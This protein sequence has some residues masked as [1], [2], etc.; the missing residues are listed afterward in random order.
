M[1]RPS[2]LTRVLAHKVGCGASWFITAS[3]ICTFTSTAVAQQYS[4]LWGQN[5]E[6]WNPA[7]SLLRD[8]TNVGYMG[9]TVPIPNWPVGVN[10]TD[11]GAIPNDGIDD[12]QAIINAIAACPH[13]HAVLV[14]KG[15][16]T[17]LQ[18]IIPARDNFV[19]R[20]EH[21][22]ESVLFF[23]KYVGEA[24]I[25]QVGWTAGRTSVDRNFVEDAFLQMNGGTG[26][27]IEN[28]SFE[29][30]EQRKASPWDYPGANAISYNNGIT[31]SWVRNVYMKNY[32]L[33]IGVSGTQLSFI[34]I[35]AD[36]FYG[37]QATDGDMSGKLDAFSAILPRN[38]SHNLYHNIDITGVVLQPIDLNGSV[39][40]SVFSKIRTSEMNSR[41]VAYHGGGSQCNLYTDLNRPVVGPFI[42][43]IYEPGSSS[44]R[45]NETYWGAEN[46]RLSDDTWST[47]TNR[48]IFVGYGN[49]WATR[50][51]TSLW[52]A[53]TPSGFWYEPDVPNLVIP[54]NLYLAQLAR[55]GEP[56]P[57]NLP[58]PV[59][60]PYEIAG[61]VFRMLPTDDIT[62]GKNSTDE[63]TAA[64]SYLKFDLTGA[65]E[66]AVAHARL[67]LT[68]K[69]IQNTPFRISAWTVTND[70][71]SETTLT[72]ANKPAVV[73]ELETKWIL[74][75]NAD[76][77]VEFDVTAFARNELVGGDRVISLCVKKQ[78]GNGFLSS[79]WSSEL[80]V[81]PELVIERT[82][83]S[84]PSPPSAPKGIRS[85]PL[86]GNIILDWDDNN[87]T[88]VETY[89]VY[90]T[91]YDYG[92][93]PVAAGLV[94]SDYVD[95]SSESDWHVGMMDYR[96]V[97]RY[98]I[99][100]VDDHG[101]ESPRSDVFVAATLHPTNA[102][103]AF[104]ATVNLAGGTAAA[105]YVGSLAGTASDP[106]SDPLFFMKV[107]GPDWLKV[108]LDGTLS[109]TP[110]L[111][112][113]GLHT[114]TF[115]VTAIGGNALKEVT[116]LVGPPVD[117]P[118]GAPAP[119]TSLNAVPGDA[120]VALN[121]DDNAEANLA[122][123]K[124]YRAS[125]SSGPYSVI[126]ASVATSSY[127]DQ[128][129]INGT[130]YHYYVTAVNTGAIE[131]AASNGVSASPLAPPPPGP[132][133]A[134]NFL[135]GLLTTPANWSNGLPLGQLGGIAVNSTVDTAVVLGGY[136]ILHTAGTVQQAGLNALEMING[137][138]WVTDGV[139]ATTATNFR[140]FALK[141]GSS[142]TLNQGTI[143]TVSGRD[144]SVMDAGSSLTVNGGS[145]ILGRSLFLSGTAGPAFTINGG[146]ISLNGTSG[147]IGA[148]SIHGNAK[149]F[150]FNG[151]ST[152]VYRL[153][154]AGANT[155]FYFGGS[156][157]GSLTATSFVGSIGTNSFLNFLPGTK[158]ALTLFGMDEWAA[159]Q[160]AAGKLR[161]NGQGVSQLGSWTAVTAANGLEPGAHFVYDSAAETLT[162]VTVD[163][164]PAAPLNLAATA[165]DST[166]NLAWGINTE[167]DFASYTIY[168]SETSGSG[169]VAIATG[170]TANAYMDLNVFNGTTYRYV[171]T[172]TDA[173]ANESGVST[174]VSAT[175]V[176]M[177]P[178]ASPTG[179]AVWVGDGMTLLNWADNSESD[180]GGYAVY[181]STTL[182]SGYSAI[183]SSLASSTY[184]DE[185]VTNGTTYHYVITALDTVGNE[186]PWGNPVSATPQVGL[187]ITSNFLGG[188]LTD[189]AN[190]NL[191]LP[192]IFL[193]SVATN[194]TVDTSIVLNGY[195]I[196]HSAGTIQ[197]TGLNALEMIN[198]S[199]WVTDGPTATTATGFRGFTL[200]S[201]SSF[202]LNQGTIHTVSG[203]DWSVMDAGS[204]LTVNGG[205]L[206]LGRHLTL[207]GTAGPTFT[208]NGGVIN[209][210][211]TTGDI[212]ASS[213]HSNAKAF[214]F[215]GGTTT[216]FR[217]NL[218]GAN[219]VFHFGGT[220]AGS[221][222]ATNFAG[223]IGTNSFLN[224]L[225]GTQMAV[226]LT[227]ANEWAATQWAAGKL[228]YNGQGNSQLGSWAAVTATGGLG[229]GYRFAYDSATETLSLTTA[230]SDDP[231]A[232][233]TGLSASPGI[234]SVSLDWANNS[235]GDLAGYSVYRS[236]S[237][238][239]LGLILASGLPT[240]QYVDSSVVDNT[241]YH[242]TVTAVDLAAQASEPSSQTS[243]RPGFVTHHTS[244]EI[245][246]DGT[247]AGSIGNVDTRDNSYQSIT[248][249][250]N[251]TTSLLEH[252]WVF[253]IT[254]AEIVTFVVEAY[255]S[256]NSESDRF[257]FAYSTDEVN[258]TD[259][260][261]ADK[262]AA[263]GTAQ[264]HVL[265]SGTSGTVY[266]R[267]RD[268]D[269]S[270]GNNGLDSINI[271]QLVIESE[272][273]STPPAAASAPSP[274]NSA[275]EVSD[276]PV[277]RWKAGRGTVSHEVY[278]GTTT[279]P[280]LLGIQ[281]GT[282]STPGLLLPNT[283]YYWS[284][285]EVNSSGTTAGPIWSFTTGN[286]TPKL[287]T[288]LIA[289]VGSVWQ[290]IELPHTY[291]SPVVVASVVYSAKTVAPAVARVRN[292]AGNSL[293]LKVQNPSGLPLSDYDVYLVVIEEGVYTAAEHGVNLEALKVD[294]VGRNE[295]NNWT[296]SQQ[297]PISPT[298]SFITPVVLGQ[299]MT[300]DDGKWSVFWSSSANR[301]NPASASSIHVGRHVGEDTDLI[302]TPETLGVIIV[303]A[304]SATF[305]GVN[306]TAQVGTDSVSG[307]G[308]NPP[309]SYP[310]T[311]LF[312][313]SG[314]AISSAAMDGN[315]GSWPVLLG[316]A[317]VT[318]TQLFLAIDE[319][320][321]ADAERKH[322][323]EQ[324]SYLVFE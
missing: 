93:L 226:T 72:T 227:A 243:A 183:A 177:T 159:T 147:D 263:D 123:Y 216:T 47:S 297:V 242:Y 145:L 161:Y 60:A 151:G 236:T 264:Y 6:L 186:S 178:P 158:M 52:N 23:P 129:A 119:P 250:S 199:T 319:D 135:G 277:L 19:L 50:I 272:T 71:W 312:S 36:Q 222:T 133:A 104:N 32:D 142:F 33:G 139:T 309:Y 34:N 16:F 289:D 258:Y 136:N 127:T 224:F 208:I 150:N 223:A 311:G 181:R 75:N 105:N 251:G 173:G 300:A 213:I 204:S 256:P 262:T 185:T 321:I 124:V 56:L 116:I 320:Q 41:T 281:A 200:K 232:A 316:S 152:T 48:A 35:I 86:V 288:G 61:D 18:K 140:G 198:G 234:G 240:S 314:V 78:E 27:S 195:K 190:W 64:E 57:E 192:T 12:S 106:E 125:S 317:P 30:R 266:V 280:D 295:N 85:T 168:R 205:T 99:T 14:P 273:S 260:L 134:T 113:E 303:E 84:V 209:G 271:D 110:G 70:N 308:D 91:P 282:D 94:T 10:I 179:L 259:M 184:T 98:W 25:E 244:A 58:I 218:A 21:M 286:V 176:D 279:P 156:A 206:N 231:P 220:A 219:T 310:L 128:T 255:H 24:Y 131:S 298:N 269:R 291:H 22:Y 301:S 169:Y 81:H 299:V 44:V 217:L 53:P 122:G 157:A 97:Y 149:T 63:L 67:R 237:Q 164:P 132:S 261:T 65:N 115:Q 49:D 203:R 257:I 79:F 148:R 8:F 265:P 13:N 294:V 141:S 323:T 92:N 143:N 174:E 43:G 40:Q 318:A 235:E 278:F 109:G 77:V 1:K 254:P 202:T 3:C 246:V 154:L 253:N 26:K 305:D 28:L 7:T 38:S 31:N 247:L 170:I 62:P 130:T 88:D 187:L 229:G 285:S 307:I 111:A 112:D 96:Q 117:E 37:R 80:G 66:P 191:G 287:S 230:P 172:A 9:G 241:T 188:L 59:P 11:F 201:K 267:V 207:S 270:A 155:V 137:S 214:H 83:S 228:R 95:T 292:A 29:F 90:R 239:G 87:E 163:L 196:L 252:V 118:V 73:S 225:P 215:N 69:S 233:P 74:N 103:P 42:D 2:F 275:V 296:S 76:L 210:N 290:T 138:A 197:Q 107:S 68:F 121:W 166:V 276:A 302:R 46:S 114:F 293:E 165:A 146:V 39:S 175:P 4:Q 45:S 313:P 306:F 102:P 249:I 108:A 17:I 15:K 211:V 180:I 126:A 212:G 194:A 322:T 274:A 167:V 89:K 268:T 315:D 54:R 20:G 120:A 55:L 5:G 182:G 160:W 171:V 221:L 153:D 162:L 100:A 51:D 324:V 193:G 144:W 248:E 283:T 101:Y 284:V 238:G 82:A 189:S 245:D 304:G